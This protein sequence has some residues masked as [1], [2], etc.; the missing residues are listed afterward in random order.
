MAT[1]N[2]NEL[3]TKQICLVEYRKMNYVFRLVLLYILQIIYFKSI[4]YLEG[5]LHTEYIFF[6][7]FH[8][9]AGPRPNNAYHGK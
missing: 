8:I 7:K 3:G 2:S 5:D 1:Y 4:H 6:C 9:V